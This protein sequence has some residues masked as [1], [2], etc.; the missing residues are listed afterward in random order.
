[1]RETSTARSSRSLALAGLSA[2]ALITAGCGNLVHQEAQAENNGV[3]VNAGPITYQLEVS[4]E[5]NQYSVED[6]QYLAGVSGASRTLAANQLWYGVFLWAKNQ[7]KASA[8]TTA[9]FVIQ[10]TE[11]HRYYP[12]AVPHTL[13]PYV[14][15]AQTL[16]AGAIEPGPDTTASFG[17]TQG[18][19]LLFKL[20]SSAYD[21]RPLILEILGP[22]RQVWGTISLDL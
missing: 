16:A 19:L 14:W 21:N 12:L 1:V 15:T 20:D 3:Y 8:P 22:S 13:N 9:N 6:S 17:P 5:L 11:G 2:L 18:G 7:N 4:R 10:D